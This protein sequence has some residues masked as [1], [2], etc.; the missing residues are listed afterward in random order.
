MFGGAPEER[1]GRA[2]L[3]TV[4][5]VR[6]LVVVEIQEVQQGG[7]QLL[8]R[9]EV[10]PSEGDPPVLVQDGALQTLDESVGPRVTGLGARV[11]DSEAVAGGVKVTP[12]LAAT[13]GED[14]L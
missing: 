2:T 5:L 10:P 8:I 4:P 1:R 7:F 11:T 14:A 9:G 12:K 3:G 6:P 13:I